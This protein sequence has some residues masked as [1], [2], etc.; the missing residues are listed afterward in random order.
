LGTPPPAVVR[1]HGGPSA[2][3]RPYFSPEAQLLAGRGFLVVAPNYRGSTGY[4]RAFEDLNNKDWGGGDLRDLIAVVD[5][6]AAR[7]DL[8]RTRVGITGGSYGGFMTLRAITATPTAWAA[9]VE[10]YGM[11]DLIADYRINSDRFGSWYETE[12]GT[13]KTHE[14]LFKDRSP[15]FNLEKVVAPLLVFQGANDSNV[16]KWESDLVVDALQK[17]GRVVDYVV[18]PNEGHGF[19]HRENRLDAVQRTAEFFGQHLAARVRPETAR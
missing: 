12:M 11:P 3:T 7:G 13:P 5:A 19:T 16:P 1:V 9:A 14:V 8:D 6:L 10:S 4:G 2:Q 18:Y 15:I 17:H